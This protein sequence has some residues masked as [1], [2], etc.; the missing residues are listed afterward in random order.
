[1][2]ATI[3]RLVELVSGS[4][5]VDTLSQFDEL[6]NPAGDAF[7]RHEQVM[8]I[9][10]E[11]GTYKRFLAVTYI[12]SA[13]DPYDDTYSVTGHTITGTDVSTLEADTQAVLDY[14][15]GS[16]TPGDYTFPAG[17]KI[18]GLPPKI[19]LSFN[20]STDLIEFE[21]TVAA[22]VEV[23]E[24]TSMT[25]LLSDLP[26]GA[27]GHLVNRT[28][29]DLIGRWYHDPVVGVRY[30][31]G[32]I[33]LENVSTARMG[34]VSTVTSP[35]ITMSPLKMTLQQGD[36]CM[37]VDISTGVAIERTIVD[38]T[39]FTATFDTGSFG[40]VGLNDLVFVKGSSEF[41]VGVDIDILEYPS[42]TGSIVEVINGSGIYIA[43]MYALFNIAD[44][45]P[46][47]NLHNLTV[48][49]VIKSS[50]TDVPTGIGSLNGPWW[51]CGVLG[52]TSAKFCLAGHAYDDTYL[53]GRYR[54]A[55]RTSAPLGLVAG[56]DT[57]YN[58]DRLD[59]AL[60][61]IG[62]PAGT[63]ARYFTG[64]AGD[65]TIGYGYSN[66][67]YTHAQLG[68]DTGVSGVAAL[69]SDIGGHG[70]YVEGYLTEFNVGFNV[71]P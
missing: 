39:G 23:Y 43:G 62:R 24:Y 27:T 18:S 64:T 33:N 40:S 3:F 17:A 32:K 60:T 46:A 63:Q 37:I 8:L 4:D 59:T 11:E 20:D 57:A 47:A 65:T 36:V 5:I 54:T 61:L 1:M 44:T 22:S 68:I 15:E 7:N 49:G 14:L 52:S 31:V 12:D 45:I 35:A 34:V 66:L 30:P 53:G 16:G 10:A 56:A 29:R 42:A 2:A 19:T 71:T 55:L 48:N 21:V 38:L 25:T 50:Y 41:D 28:T 67:A 58:E 26:S 51:G 9:K 69:I 6:Y 70:L 13:Y